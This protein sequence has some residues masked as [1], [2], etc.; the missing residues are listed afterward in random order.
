MPRGNIFP[1]ALASSFSEEPMLTVSLAPSHCILSGVSY[2]SLPSALTSLLEKLFSSLKELSQC[3]G[4]SCFWG[5]PCLGL[6][7]CPSCLL[8]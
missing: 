1:Q 2:T 6:V 3:Q 7:S 4:S 8:S 5:I